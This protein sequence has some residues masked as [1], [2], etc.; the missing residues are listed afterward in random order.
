MSHL[1]FNPWTETKKLMVTY[2]FT[3]NK[4]SG[5]V[6]TSFK[7]RAVYRLVSITEDDSLSWGNRLNDVRRKVLS[8]F[9][10]LNNR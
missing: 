8:K 5:Q 1:K 6:C 4:C 9:R 2:H 10:S 7:D 3:D